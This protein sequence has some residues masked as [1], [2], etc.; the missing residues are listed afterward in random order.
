MFVSA[1]TRGLSVGIIHFVSSLRKR[2]L[3]C[4]LR[5]GSFEASAVRLAIFE[6]PRALWPKRPCPTACAFSAH[7]ETAKAAVDSKFWIR[8][9]K[10][11]GFA[12]VLQK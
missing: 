8:I 11:I 9:L 7:S 12:E 3:S 6:D 1:F 5:C 4:E 2:K 10:T